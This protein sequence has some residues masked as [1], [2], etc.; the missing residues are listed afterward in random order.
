L[1][2][3]IAPEYS[4]EYERM[5]IGVQLG[6]GSALPW[7][8]YKNPV[9]QLKSDAMMIVRVVQALSSRSEAKQAAKNLGGPVAIFGM[10]IFSI[11]TGLLNTLGLIRLLNV[12]LALL[13]LLPIPVLDGGHI[14]FSLWEGLTRRKVNARVQ[15]VL[16]NICAVLLIGAMLLITFNDINR[17]F[18]VKKFFG[19][20]FSGRIEAA[21]P[22]APAEGE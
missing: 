5:M 21:A 14:M 18:G 6:G 22:S 7:M 15:S 12:N 13:N 8:L 20:L 11:K 3:T 17:Q 1:A 2:L 16:V 9:D 19:K 4:D 10:L